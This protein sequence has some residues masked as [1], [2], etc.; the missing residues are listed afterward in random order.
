MICKMANFR[1]LLVPTECPEVEFN[2]DERL[3]QEMVSVAQRNSAYAPTNPTL[4]IKAFYASMPY[5]RLIHVSATK[6]R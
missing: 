4:W 3:W 1:L 6:P 5:H 2:S